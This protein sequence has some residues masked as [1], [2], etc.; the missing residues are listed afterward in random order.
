MNDNENRKRDMFLRAHQFFSTRPADFATGSIG[1]QLITELGATITEL[2]DHAAAE[3]SGGGAARE[4]TITRAQARAA[5]REDLEAI[6]RT[7]RLLDDEPGLR[8]KFRVPRGR[9]DQQLLDAGRSAAVDAV[10]YKARFIAHELPAD[11]LEDLEADITA[12]EQSVGEQ[13]A[14]HGGRVAASAAI[15]EAI[16]RGTTIVRKLDGI[17][18]NKYGNQRATMA[19]WTSAS[20]TERAPRKKAGGGSAPPSAGGPPSSPPPSG[21]ST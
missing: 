10:P 9:N 11:F 18:K 12:M 16:E 13:S 1:K 4:G 15:D 20:H 2:D 3:T 19:E 6:N 14:G 5:L 21:P 17:V 7:A 8:E